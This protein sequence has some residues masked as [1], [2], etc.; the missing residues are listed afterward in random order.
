MADRSV[1]IFNWGLSRGALANNAAAMANGFWEVGV[2]ELYMVYLCSG[3]GS[4]VAL[5]EGVKLISLGVQHSRQAPIRLARFIRAVK[6]DVLISMVSVINMAAILGW[7]LAGRGRTKLVISEHATMS[8]Q[9]YVEHKHYL[10]LRALPRLARLLYPIADGLRANSQPVLDDLLT[11]IRVPMRHDRVIA[12]PNP[13]NIDAVSAHSRAEPEHPWLRQKDKPVIVSVARLAKHKNLPLLLKAFGIVR[14]TM[15]ARLVIV[16]EGPERKHLESLIHELGFEDVSLPGYSDNPWRTMARADVFV[17]PSEEE[18]FGLVLVEAMACGVP[19][20]ATDAIGGGPR[21]VLENGRYGILVPSN[22]V[23]ALA[24]AIL[25]VLGS[26]DLRD[27]LM[28][29]GKQRCEAFRPETVA[30]QW[31]S[32]IERLS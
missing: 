27:R 18:A 32:F 6:P 23:E 22:D 15:D 9:V 28:H 17:L 11:K 26:K 13:V 25:K 19:V 20:V 3:P 24:E 8:Y 21:S 1:A 31:L 29:A 30:Q 5:P 10:R 16:G 7:L 2:R 14:Q 4:Y 12:I